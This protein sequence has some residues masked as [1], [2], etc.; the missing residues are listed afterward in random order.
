MQNYKYL[1]N[2]LLE[3]LTYKK[4]F[5]I[6]KELQ[7]ANIKKREDNL[8]NLLKNNPFKINKSIFEP[9]V[10][11][12]DKSSYIE[13]INSIRDDRFKEMMIDE[14]NLLNDYKELWNKELVYEFR[15]LRG[16]QRDRKHIELF[17]KL[18]FNNL[19]VENKKIQIDENLN[20]CFVEG[21]IEIAT[22]LSDILES[23]ET[24][25][26]DGSSLFFRGH[27]NASYRLIPSIYRGNAPFYEKEIFY[28]TIST[29]PQEVNGISS[30]FEILTKFQHFGTPTRLL[31][32]TTNPLVALFFACKSRSSDGELLFFSEENKKIKLFDSDTV[33]VVT[34][35]V[36][37]PW[38]FWVNCTTDTIGSSNFDELTHKIRN[39]KPYFQNIIRCDDLKKSFFVKPKLD[40][41]RIIKQS[42]AFIVCGMDD[43]KYLPSKEIYDIEKNKVIKRIIISKHLKDRINK[44]LDVFSISSGTLFPGLSDVASYVKRKYG[45][46]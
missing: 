34:N 22:K 9:F 20:L 2:Y 27:D 13:I 10:K 29:I 39:E 4:H 8:K 28:D 38:H 30:A 24:L 21:Q 26:K 33:S 46:K 6:V 25:Q 36:K 44:S 19:R 31:D 37:L 12:N 40:N 42:G 1:L 14:L 17:Q 23:I 11:K 43:I 15:G 16:N 32:I 7:Q 35:L 41:P 5:N 18:F 3:I 45:V